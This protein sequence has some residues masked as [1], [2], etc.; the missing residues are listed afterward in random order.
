VLTKHRAIS[1]VSESKFNK[2]VRWF[3][4]HPSEGLS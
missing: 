1:F 4:N 2:F 3:L